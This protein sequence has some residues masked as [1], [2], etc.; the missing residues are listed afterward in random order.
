MTWIAILLG[1]AALC[2]L[3]YAAHR[4]GRADAEEDARALDEQRAAENLY[5]HHRRHD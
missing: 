3:V 2:L 4:A 5:P 1:L